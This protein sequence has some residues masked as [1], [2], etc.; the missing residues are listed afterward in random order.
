MADFWRCFSFFSGLLQCNLLGSQWD[1]NKPPG[2][3]PS[4]NDK[5]IILGWSIPL[6]KYPFK[7]D[8][9]CSEERWRCP[10]PESEILKCGGN[11]EDKHAFDLQIITWN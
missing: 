2:S 11:P 10:D 3:H 5:I 9:N 1:S 6:H 7:S 8:W 4:E